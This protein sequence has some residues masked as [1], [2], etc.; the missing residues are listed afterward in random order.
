M[1][2]LKKILCFL[3]TACILISVFSVGAYALDSESIR[4]GYDYNNDGKVNLSD[5]RTVLKVSAGIEAPAEGKIY[6]FDGDGYVTYYDVR[7]VLSIALGI[8]VDI[9]ESASQEYLLSLFADEL[10][11][12]KEKRPGFAKT[13]TTQCA[14]A[15]ITTR[16]S[17]STDYDV[18]DM[19]FSDYIDFMCTDI[20]KILEIFDDEDNKLVIEMLPDEYKAQIEE[21]RQYYNQLQEQKTAFYE[22]ETSKS[23]VMRNSTN[24]RSRFLVNSSSFASAEKDLACNLSVQD[25]E[26]I[27]CYEQDGYVYRVVTMKDFSYVGD[28]YPSGS[29]GAYKRWQEI[30]YGKVFSIPA[31]NENDTTT[32]NAISF[33]DGEITVKTDKLTG[34]PVAVDY[35]YTYIADMTNVTVSDSNTTTMQTVTTSVVS[36]SYTINSVEAN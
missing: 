13:S 5:A 19:E 1:K 3:I 18:T 2:A 14:S 27:N 24:H 22:P 16:S 29:S 11:S 8:D 32:L 7:T 26:S 31:L 15:R 35:S 9:D 34:V 23:T 30:P 4:A 21:L 20:V 33:K 36:E 12:V 10:N 25:I 6:D 28:E 17:A